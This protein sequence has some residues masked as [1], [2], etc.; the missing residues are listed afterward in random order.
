MLLL[1][2]Q[3]VR[4]TARL[5]IA[6][7]VPARNEAGVIGRSLASL[8]Q[9][10]CVDALH[11]VVVDDNS[12]DATANVAKEVASRNRVTVIAGRPLPSG[13]SGKL[14]AV[15]QGIEQALEL[16]PDFLLLTDADIEHS[17]DNVARLVEIA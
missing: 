6:A 12:S 7:V 3:H 5:T 8:L 2:Q 13:W 14:W 4:T 11:V 1:V 17:R 16:N 15:Q 10:I 9:Q